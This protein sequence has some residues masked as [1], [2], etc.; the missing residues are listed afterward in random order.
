MLS[1]LFPRSSI[2]KSLDD[3]DNAHGFD[4]SNT[5]LFDA[6]GLEDGFDHATSRNSVTGRRGHVSQPSLPDPF[7]HMPKTGTV[8]QQLPLI[9]S[10]PTSPASATSQ[11]YDQAT[12]PVRDDESIHAAMSTADPFTNHEGFSNDPMTAMSERLNSPYG[13]NRHNAAMR[14]QQDGLGETHTLDEGGPPKS[15]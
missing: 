5:A 9:K 4:T 12:A 8:P 14:E 11:Q 15:M 6:D 2:Y 13:T 3:R 7:E 10:A 1:S